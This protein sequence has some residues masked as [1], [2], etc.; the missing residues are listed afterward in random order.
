MG[1]GSFAFADHVSFIPLLCAT[2]DRGPH[3]HLSGECLDKP[4]SLSLQVV[5]TLK[6]EP[7]LLRGTKE[8][9]QAQ[10]GVR[11]YRAN[12]VND[13]VD[14]TRGHVSTL[15]ETILCDAHR[16]QEVLGQYFPGM[17]GR[18]HFP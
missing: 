4:I 10:R 9:S 17:D 7:K 16:S 3:L 2:R 1:R 18:L 12:A 14:S 5:S 11:R 15:C 6:V 13:F 8:A